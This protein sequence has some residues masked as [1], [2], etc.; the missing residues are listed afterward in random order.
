MKTVTVANGMTFSKDTTN[1]D[2]ESS[3]GKD[4]A[5][6]SENSDGSFTVTLLKNVTLKEGAT[7]PI[8]F[9]YSE[10]GKTSQ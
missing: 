7:S 2:I 1:A 9:G 5:T 3:W 6:I 4:I 8:T 10:M